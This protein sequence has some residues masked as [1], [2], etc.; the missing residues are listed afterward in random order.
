MKVQR[1]EVTF[2]PVM[3][4]EEARRLQRER[5]LESRRRHERA[6]KYR[7]L[8]RRIRAWSPIGPVS[9]IVILGLVAAYYQGNLSAARLGEAGSSRAWS[10]DLIRRHHQASRN[11]ASAYAVGL[12]PARRGEPGYWDHLDADHDGV[13]CEWWPRQ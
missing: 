12:A 7:Q 6:M 8:F 3:S 4:L 13:S 1:R 2:D 10:D 11:C 5:N 9:L